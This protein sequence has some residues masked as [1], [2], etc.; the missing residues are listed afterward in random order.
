MFQMRWIWK[1]MGK[2][3]HLF[4]WGLVLS[5]AAS[6]VTLINPLLSQRLIDDVITPEK[7]DMLLPILMI[8]LAVQVARLSMRY[9]MVAFLEKNSQ[10]SVNDIRRAMYDVI[11]NQDWRF[12]Q[13]MRTGNLMS[14]MTND[15]DML[16]HALAFVSYN[17]IDTVT[18][19]TG[20]VITLCIINLKLT[21]C[22]LVIVPVIA[23][24]ARLFSRKVQPMFVKLRQRLTDL[25]TVV[26]E[27]IEGN[28]VV[29]AFSREAYEKQKFDEK[30]AGFRDTQTTIA[31]MVA[32][33][34]PV[35]ELMSQSLTVTTLLVGG[36]FLIDGSL[37]MGQMMAFNLL[38]WALA[39]PMRNLANI[40]ADVQRF[41]TS[42]NMLIEVFYAQPGIVD[43]VDAASPSKR[44]RG[45][46]AFENV[47]FEAGGKQVLSNVSFEVA[48]GQT[49]GILGATGSGKTSLVN[50]LMRYY[51]PTQGQVLL[52][53]KDVT[54][55]TLKA[56]R[57][58]MGFAMQDVFLFSDSVSANI[59][60]GRADL[61]QS[62]IEQRA[63]QADA[64]SFVRRMD[65]GYDTL[66]GERGVGMSGGQKQRISLARALAVR[67][68]VLVLDDTTSAV[69]MET[70]Q[71]IQRQLRELDYPCTK[72]IIAQRLS[73]FE[74]A[75]L[76]LVL[77]EGRIIERGTHEELLAQKGSYWRTWNIQCGLGV[78]VEVV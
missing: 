5:F 16:R 57:G 42:C 55:Y 64:D 77:D 22:L 59:A 34:G 26:Q 46:I 51:E 24:V 2:K 28:R 3:R 25:N 58:S 65:D 68:S 67:P 66:V 7:T 69:D 9:A 43:R 37:T 38:S 4:V 70:E 32:R 33:F 62:E 41:Y 1:Q 78:E 48:A 31:F 72:I 76:I 45:D 39:G 30:N 19:F 75:D 8:M 60:Y 29:K 44:V 21:L 73:S 36:L 56:L 20:A 18:L 13:R 35:L 17:I 40:V 52:D 6:V 50:L 54:T 23:V 61:A 14:R 49:L 11:Q 10:Q 15:L 12:S 63:K 53:N 47:S 71:Y 74:S 27:N